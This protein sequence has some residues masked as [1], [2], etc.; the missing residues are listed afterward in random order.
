MTFR[1]LDPL[2]SAFVTLEVPSAPLHI[3]V[4]IELDVTDDLDPRERF[5]IIKANVAARVH[6]IPVLSQRILR[7]PFDLAWPVCAED[8]DFDID[9]HVVRR[10]VPSPGGEAELDALV[11]RVMSR[12]L[13]PD[14]PLWELNVIEGLADGRAAIVMKI[15]HALADGVS[16]AATFARLFDISPSV[17]EP[18]PRE[19]TAAPAPLPTPIEMLSR[20]AGELLRRPGAL[21]EVV[22]AGMERA[23]EVIERVAK[24]VEPSD[25]ESQDDEY[26]QPNIFHAQRTS[27]NGTPGHSKKFTRL[28]VDLNEVKT[29]AKS[30]GASVTDFVMATVSGGLRRLFDARGEV[31]TK[32]LVAFVPINVRRQGAEDAMGNQISAMLLGLRTDV[33]DP[34]ERLRAITKAQAIAAE[35]QREQSARLLM[36]LAAAAGPTFT[37][38]AG[39]TLAA[40]ELYDHLPPVANV[41]VSSVPGPPIPLWLSGHRVATAAPLGPLMAG[42]ALNVT[43]FGYVDQLEYGLLGCA[44]LIPELADLRDY[45]AEEADYFLKTPVPDE[46]LVD[47]DS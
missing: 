11:G 3:G 40:L 14:R 31:L 16:G 21:V 41:V 28:R 32:D 30:R 23:A 24:T 45:I 6:E 19:E 15:H 27:I 44:R 4:I 47:L 10:A 34:E 37:S 17:R 18:S 1:V 29:A 35:Q 25:T 2:D 43:V 26:K 7:T 33:E 22:A 42:L 38:A 46:E 9:F 20:T 5:E 39:R 8:P 36:N 13:V 12:E